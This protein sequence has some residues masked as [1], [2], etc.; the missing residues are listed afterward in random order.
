[1]VWRNTWP[2]SGGAM[3]VAV[4]ASPSSSVV[5]VNAPPAALVTSGPVAVSFNPRDSGASSTGLTV[6]VKL[7]LVDAKPSEML[8]VRCATPER[9]GAGL[10]F[11]ERPPVPPGDVVT[12]RLRSGSRAGLSDDTSSMISRPG[13]CASPTVKATAPTSSSFITT[14]AMGV[15]VGGVLMKLA[16]KSRP[17]VSA[18][19]AITF[20]KLF[21]N[22]SPLPVAVIW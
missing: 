19:T 14:S 15:L 11:I 18:A 17:V 5:V 22:V 1:M 6:T 4:S 20:G 21:A 10:N 8:S 3:S 9:P 16:V 12:R 2:L 13:D 7:T